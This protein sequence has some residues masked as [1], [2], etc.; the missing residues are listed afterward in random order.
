MLMRQKLFIFIIG[1]FCFTFVLKN[2]DTL[3]AVESPT[4]GSTSKP[5]HSVVAKDPADLCE[6]LSVHDKTSEYKWVK[7]NGDGKVIAI[8]LHGEHVND[9]NVRLLAQ[10]PELTSISMFCSSNPLSSD[11]LAELGKLENLEALT[12]S[13]LPPECLLTDDHL[14]GIGRMK[15]LKS[16]CI[17]YVK[18]QPAGIRHFVQLKKLTALSI[19][20][21]SKFTL[22][23][24]TSIKLIPK[25]EKL[26]L[27]DVGFTAKDISDSGLRDR[28]K[29]TFREN[30]KIDS[31]NEDIKAESK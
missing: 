22:E 27:Y 8:V 13:S 15:N 5:A 16:L 2:G 21:S 26:D 25:L 31:E 7:R 4:N 24:L 11:A 28:I 20:S 29:I 17:R 12:I 30:D 6:L 14:A 19:S 23:S 9:G 18:I 10:M 1:L 3:R